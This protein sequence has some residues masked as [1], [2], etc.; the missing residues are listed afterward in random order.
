MNSKNKITMY[1]KAGD[2]K[3]K[4]DWKMEKKLKYLS[5]EKPKR[6]GCLINFFD[7]F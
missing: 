1:S 3:F 2:C 7:T 5:F 6:S 4:V